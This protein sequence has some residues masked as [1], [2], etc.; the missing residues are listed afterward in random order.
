MQLILM[1]INKIAGGNK[2]AAPLIIG[3]VVLVCA[4]AIPISVKYFGPNNVIEQDA[5]EIIQEEAPE[6]MTTLES[7]IAQA[8]PAQSDV[9][10]KSE[11]S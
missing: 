2:M 5:K 1:L 9:A 11:N 7:G 6:V 3:A 10:T 8:A 4:I